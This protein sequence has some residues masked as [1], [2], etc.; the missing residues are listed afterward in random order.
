MT[1]G[2]S[3]FANGKLAPLVALYAR[4]L[5]PVVTRI[6]SDK[7]SRAVILFFA[8][9][10]FLVSINIMGAGFKTMEDSAEEN[11]AT[12]IQDPISA[13]CVGLLITGIIQSSS[14]TTSILVAMVAAPNSP[15]EVV[16]IIPAIMGA[17]IGTAV[18]NTIVSLGHLGRKEEFRLAFGG[19]LV[20]D[21]FNLLAV[22]IL[23]P[24]ELLFHPLNT[25][26]SGMAFHLSDSDGITFTSPIKAATKPLVKFA[27]SMADWDILG[28]DTNNTTFLILLG[29][30]ALFMSMKLIVMCT[31][32]FVDEYGDALVDKYMFKGPTQSFALGLGLTATVQ[33]SSITTSLIIPLIGSGVLKIKKVLPY[34]IGANIGT[35]VTTL[36]AALAAMSV[37]AA[38]D[39]SAPLIIAFVHLLFNISGGAIIYGIKPLRSIPIFLAEKSG[40]IAS[41]SRKGFIALVGGYVIGGIYLFPIS[42][43]LL[44]SMF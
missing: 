29:V 38:T 2:I 40:E 41:E 31:R 9:Y 21:Y 17:N 26:A 32:L 24:I 18:T 16:D 27:E 14:G 43:L 23:L 13:L 20:H 34:T 15:I 22:I 8:I 25:A 33:S 36:M 12:L 37:A 4:Y 7:R 11:F 3:E 1:N 19:S 30:L 5:D 10:I 39:S 44:R 42:Y 28:W 35:T 6:M